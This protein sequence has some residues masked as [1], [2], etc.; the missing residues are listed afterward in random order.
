M[1]IKASEILYLLTG[2]LLNQ[3]DST[4]NKLIPPWTESTESQEDLTTTTL[5]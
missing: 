4:S 3:I 1:N 2:S 5:I